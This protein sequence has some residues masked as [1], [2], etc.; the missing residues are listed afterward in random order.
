MEEEEKKRRKRRRKKEGDD[1]EDD[2]LRSAKHAALR[3]TILSDLFLLSFSR[4]EVFS[5]H[6][7]LKQSQSVLFCYSG[8]LRS[9]IESKRCGLY[10][11]IRIFLDRNCEKFLNSTPAVISE[12][13]A[14]LTS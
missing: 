9:K 1:V 4:M 7:V 10:I 6:L 3:Y 8:R 14:F 12:F 2:L 11:L 13:K 5:Q